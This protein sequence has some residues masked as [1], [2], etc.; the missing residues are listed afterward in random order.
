M[1]YHILSNINKPS[2]IKTLST[3]QLEILCD[4]I[5]DKLTDMGIVLEDTREGVKWKR[6]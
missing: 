3:N 2:D 5:R 6:A 1:N 4:E